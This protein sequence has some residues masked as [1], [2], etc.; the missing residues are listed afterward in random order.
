MKKILVTGGCGFIGSNFIRHLLQLQDDIFIINI[1]KLTY[2]G[3]M[4]NLSDINGLNNYAF[5]RQ[6]ICHDDAMQAIFKQGIDYVINFAAESHVDRSIEDSQVFIKSNILGTQVLLNNSLKYGVKKYIQI[7]TDEVYGSLSLDGTDAFAEDTPLSPRNPY[8]ATKASADMLVK[9]YYH[10]YGL[11]VMI[12]RCSN[13]YGEFQHP[14]KLIPKTIVNAIR[15]QPIGIYGDGLNVRDWIY[16]QDHC[17]AIQRVL[18]KGIA[19]EVYNIGA[20]YEISNIDIVKHI[21]KHLGK[22]EDLIKFTKDRPGHDRRYAMNS[23]KIQRELGW[24]PKTDFQIGIANTIEWYM[25]NKDW[26]KSVQQR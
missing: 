7:S 25:R 16:V 21:L 5:I 13:N 1:D 18:E 11:P 4:R 10:T 2:A 19:G 9:S 22:T 12:T 14:E 3:N 23:G 20:N 26:W 15:E 17:S 24:T 6:D 8:S